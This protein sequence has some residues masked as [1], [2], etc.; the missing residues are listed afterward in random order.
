MHGLFP[1]KRVASFAIGDHHAG[2]SGECCVAQSPTSAGARS[3]PAES[4]STPGRLGFAGESAGD[5]GESSIRYAA[6][7][8]AAFVSPATSAAVG[9][10]TRRRQVSGNK[11]Q[12]TVFVI[13]AGLRK[14]LA[15]GTIRF[16]QACI[17]PLMPLACRF[18]PSCSAYAFE[19]VDRWGAFKGGRLAL[20]RLLRCRP[21]GSF[22]YDPVP[23]K[24]DLG[25]AEFR[26]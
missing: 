21:W 13:L 11:K 25:R 26:A 17:S 5:G 23:E 1:A 4:G 14:L 15:L 12:G 16:Y 3:V 9:C 22:G 10:A 24:Q 19:A 7:G 18:Q 6:T 8:T 2:A 20:G